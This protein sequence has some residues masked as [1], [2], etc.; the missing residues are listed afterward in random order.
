MTKDVAYPS[1]DQFQSVRVEIRDQ[2]GSNISVKFYMNDQLIT[3]QY[4]Y[5]YVGERLNLYVTGQSSPS[6]ESLLC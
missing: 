5:N 4:G 1:P 3:T 2:D 6:D